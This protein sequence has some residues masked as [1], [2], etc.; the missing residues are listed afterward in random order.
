MDKTFS[1]SKNDEPTRLRLKNFRNKTGGNTDVDIE[2]DEVFLEACKADLGK[3]DVTNED[4][5]SYI[6]LL[7]EKAT[8]SIDGYKLE[9]E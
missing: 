5:S 3:S 7:I 4:L 8:M 2:Y 9:V 6:S 1:I